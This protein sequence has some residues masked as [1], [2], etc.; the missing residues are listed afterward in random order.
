[1]CHPH[2][3]VGSIKLFDLLWSL[4]IYLSTLKH[5]DNMSSLSTLF[6]FEHQQFLCI[7]TDFQN[8]PDAYLQKTIVIKQ[9]RWLSTCCR[10]SNTTPTRDD[11]R[12]TSEERTKLAEI[13]KSLANAGNIATI[14]KKI[15]PG[16]V[17]LPSRYRGTL[18][19]L[20]WLDTRDEAIERLSSSAI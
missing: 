3:L 19:G 5:T 15:A 12:S 17:I 6:F 9:V 2:Q 7:N 10:V 4:Q 14:A 18:Y 1:M 8:V 16:R 13:P 20:A 11:E